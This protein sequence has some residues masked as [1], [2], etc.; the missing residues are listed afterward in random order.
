MDDK[1]Q[2][3]ANT[4]FAEIDNS[5]NVDDRVEKTDLLTKLSNGFKEAMSILS[6]QPVGGGPAPGAI[7]A[8]ELV[9]T[10]AGKEVGSLLF[11]EQLKAV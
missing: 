7:G 11:L 3:L 2:N 9:E 10:D 1:T 8:S 4:T 6:S 5:V